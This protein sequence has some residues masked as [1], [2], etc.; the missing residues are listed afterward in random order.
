MEE[1]KRKEAA[2]VGLLS[3]SILSFVAAVHLRWSTSWSA[4][5]AQVLDNRQQQH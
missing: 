4:T 3:S 1:M 2:F 5:A